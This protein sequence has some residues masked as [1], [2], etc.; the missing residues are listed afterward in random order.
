MKKILLSLLLLC[1]NAFAQTGFETGNLTGWTSSGGDNT[2]SQALTNFSAGGGK[3]WTINPYGSWMGKLYPSGSVQFDNATTSLGLNSTENSAIKS[4]LNLQASS[5]GGGNPTP[6]NASW[7]KKTMTLT[8]GT[9]YSFAWN[10]L[11]T[12]Y[13]PFNDGSMI[14]LVHAT[15]ASICLLYTSPS[16]RDRQK[17]RMPSSA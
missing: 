6:T 3:T 2:A 17:S 8:A 11:S 16:P 5:G 15:N 12:D 1:S 13:T 9:N 10:Y 4:Y 7:M 14:T